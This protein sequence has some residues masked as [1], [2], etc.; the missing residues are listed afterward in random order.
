MNLFSIVNDISYLQAYYYTPHVLKWV[1]LVEDAGKSFR[2]PAN[3][4][5]E[6]VK[7]LSLQLDL[8][9]GALE[10]CDPMCEAELYD[11]ILLGAGIDVVLVELDVDTRPC[12]VV[13]C[14]CEDSGISMYESVDHVAYFAWKTEECRVLWFGRFAAR[15]E[16]HTPKT[17]QC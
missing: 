14:F 11:F 2:R 5:P 9:A 6:G 3:V 12:E 15:Y 17:G 1:W 8:T 7:V 16:K 13:T 4:L 10:A